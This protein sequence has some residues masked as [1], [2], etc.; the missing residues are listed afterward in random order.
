MNENHDQRWSR[1][2]LHM[3]SLRDRVSAAEP[4]DPRNHLAQLLALNYTA[5]SRETVAA[6]MINHA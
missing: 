6:K 2:C 4:D 3:L 5:A 1:S